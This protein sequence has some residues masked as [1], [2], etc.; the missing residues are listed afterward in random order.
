AFGRQNWFPCHAAEHRAAREAVAI[1][2][3]TGFSKF[4]F[5][6]RDVLAVL[7]RLCGNNVDVPVGRAV[8]TGLF[9]ERGGIESDLTVIRLGVAEFLVITGS[10]QTLRDFDWISHNILPNKKTI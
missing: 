10:S 5:K 8:Y 1:F 4:V 2:D 6:G 9:N 3:Q 7:Q